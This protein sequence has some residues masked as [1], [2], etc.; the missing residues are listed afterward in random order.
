MVIGTGG[1]YRYT[2]WRAPLLPLNVY[3][4]S[5]YP[6][7]FYCGSTFTVGF[8]LR[9]NI[10][11]RTFVAAPLLLDFYR[12]FHMPPSPYLPNSLVV[13]AP[14]LQVFIFQP[15]SQSFSVVFDVF[16]ALLCFNDYFLPQTSFSILPVSLT[17]FCDVS[18]RRFLFPLSSSDV[19]YRHHQPT[20]DVD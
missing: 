17:D 12:P 8:L 1:R 14:N 20:S 2:A 9:L 4:G 11:L 18:P 5:T 6:L 19:S 16:S 10:S 7:D 13:R 15:I 3:R